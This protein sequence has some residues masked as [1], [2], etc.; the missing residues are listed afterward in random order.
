MT[1]QTL[2]QAGG[3]M[4]VWGNPADTFKKSFLVLDPACS[5][6]PYPGVVII[7]TRPQAAAVAFTV[8]NLRKELPEVLLQHAGNAVVFWWLE[9]DD[10]VR[11]KLLEDLTASPVYADHLH[12]FPSRP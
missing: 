3:L 8:N 6:D 10:A 2:I 1:N 7:S 12:F 4:L 11:A 5:P 9:R